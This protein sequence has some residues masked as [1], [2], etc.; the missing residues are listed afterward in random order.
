MI[1]LS[2]DPGYNNP[3]YTIFNVSTKIDSFT[4]NKDNWN[5]NWEDKIYKLIKDCNPLYIIIEKQGNKYSKNNKYIYFIRGI[6][7]VLDIKCILVNPISYT[8]SV[9]LPYNKRKQF[10]IDLYNEINNSNIND[11]DLADSFNIGYYY[12]VNKLGCISH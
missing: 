12:I 3:A 1:I 9:K 4:M 8:S 10:S 6:C 7:T 11:A 5:K 2:I